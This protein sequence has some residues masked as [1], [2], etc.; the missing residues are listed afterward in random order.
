MKI[1]C[2]I[3]ARGGSIG[4]KNKN[5]RL[6][7]GKPLIAHSILQAKKSNLF[8]LIVVS[9]DSPKIRVTSQQW[10]AD[11]V[12]NRPKELATSTAPKIPVIQHAVSEIELMYGSKFDFIIDLDVT[13]PLRIIDDIN[14]AFNMLV[15]H[16]KATNLVTACH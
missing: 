6:L 11:Y 8:D 15:E 7:N 2:T 3:C 13:S 1:L 12:I 14:G 9:S 16:P 10:G 5:I 4:V